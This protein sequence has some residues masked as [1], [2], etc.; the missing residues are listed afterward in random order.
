VAVSGSLGLAAEGLALLFERAVDAE[1]VPDA[2]RAHALRAEFPAAVA[3]QLTPRPPLADGVAAALAGATAMLDVSDGLVIDARRIADASGVAIDLD[4]SAIGSP[5]IST[6]SA[7]SGGEDHALLATFPAAL[8]QPGASLPGGF[9]RIGTVRAGT[10]LTVDGREY[11][12]RGGWDPYD[13]WNGAA[14]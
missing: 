14:G 13:G 10:G 3:A 8:M 2:T 11:R 4:A 9:R 5:G 1:G 7:L 12:E 6:Q